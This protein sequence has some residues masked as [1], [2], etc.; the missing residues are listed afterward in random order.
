MTWS[1]RIDEIET[2]SATI[3]LAGGEKS[4]ARQHS[5]GRMTARERIAELVPFRP[6]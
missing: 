1:Q 4:I 6:A 2:Q 3:G 5:K